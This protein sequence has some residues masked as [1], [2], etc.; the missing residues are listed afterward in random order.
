[1]THSRAQASPDTWLSAL[2]RGLADARLQFSRLQ[3]EAAAQLAELDAQIT[4]LEAAIRAEEGHL[5]EPPTGGIIGGVTAMAKRADPLPRPLR[6][7]GRYVTT[8]H[9][10]PLRAGNVREWARQH[11]VDYRAVKRWYSSSK[12]GSPIP[13]HWALTIQQEYSVSLM[14]WPNGVS[15]RDRDGK[16]YVWN[17]R[18]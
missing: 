2:R 11:D 17:R 12:T 13:E 1:M 18:R 7:H 6:G 10:F 8:R 5:S 4:G 16:R 15:R 14:S 9:P 3:V